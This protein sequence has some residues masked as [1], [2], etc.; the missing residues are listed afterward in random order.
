MSKVILK[1]CPI[2]RVKESDIQRNIVSWFRTQYPKYYRLLFH[3]PNGVKLPSRIN[4][5]FFKRQ[6]MTSGVADL[7]LLKQSGDKMYG[8]L[9]L[10]LKTRKGKQ[11]TNQREW[12]KDITAYSGGKYNVARSVEEGISIIKAYIGEK[13]ES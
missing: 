5:A 9:A 3:V 12:E 1:R 10:E 7:I 8:F 11:T 13:S 4:G 2:K 6:G